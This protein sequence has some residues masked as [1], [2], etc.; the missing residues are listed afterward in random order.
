VSRKFRLTSRHLPVEKLARRCSSENGTRRERAEF[1]RNSVASSRA[2]CSLGSFNKQV[3]LE[4]STKPFVGVQ[5]QS[6]GTESLRGI[7]ERLSRPTC[8]VL[9]VLGTCLAPISVNRQVY[10]ADSHKGDSTHRNYSPCFARETSRVRSDRKCRRVSAA[11]N[12]SN[13]FV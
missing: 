10:S 3:I 1:N 2:G 5:N 6:L 4:S 13:L 11:G 7:S 12:G 9:K 8:G